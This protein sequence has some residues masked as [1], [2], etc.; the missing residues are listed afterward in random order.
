MRCM[1][2]E[3]CTDMVDQGSDRKY[4]QCVFQ[5]QQT[6]E[7]Q[8]DAELASSRAYLVPLTIII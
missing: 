7:S 3:E 2:G 4:K 6:H 1:L 5:S 8:T